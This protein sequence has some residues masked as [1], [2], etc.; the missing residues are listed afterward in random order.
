MRMRKL[1][2]V[3][4]I[5]LISIAS[6]AV[7]CNQYHAAVVIEHDFKIGVEAAQ[8][9]EISEHTAGNIDD[10]THK[11]FEATFLKIGQGG[12][13]TAKLM[14]ANSSKQSVLAEANLISGSLNDLLAEGTLGIKNPTTLNNLKI[15][16]KGVQDTLTNFQTFLGGA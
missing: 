4:F 3:S 2:L 10:A 14:A 9:I 7:S 13:A 8:N 16:I 11:Q 1:I 6:M 15:A 12:E 5:I